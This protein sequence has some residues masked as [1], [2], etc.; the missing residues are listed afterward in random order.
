VKVPA[1]ELIYDVPLQALERWAGS[2][3]TSPKAHLAKRLVRKP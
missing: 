3:S 2:P 1:L